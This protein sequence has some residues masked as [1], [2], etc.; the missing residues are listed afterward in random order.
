MFDPFLSKKGV[1]SAYFVPFD[2]HEDIYY[3]WN[4]GSPIYVLVPPDRKGYFVMTSYSTMVDPSMVKTNIVDKVS[5]LDMPKG[6]TFETRILDKP[7]IVRTQPTKNFSHQVLFDQLQN[8]YHY[9]E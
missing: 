3:I 5:E 9:V 6:W 7:L 4:K 1:A 2:S 8:F